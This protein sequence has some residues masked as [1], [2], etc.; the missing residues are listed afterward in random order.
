V[1]KHLREYDLRSKG[2]DNESTDH[3]QL[4]KELVWLILH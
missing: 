1:I 3:G 4:L 2:V